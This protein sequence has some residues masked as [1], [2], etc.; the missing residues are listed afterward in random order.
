VSDHFLIGEL[1]PVGALD[2]SVE[3]QD[4]TKGFRLE[5]AKILEL[6]SSLVN[7]LSDLDG[8]P[9]QTVYVETRGRGNE[10]GVAQGTPSGSVSHVK[11]HLFLL[12]TCPGHITDSSVNQPSRATFIPA[13]VP[14]AIVF[15][16]QSGFRAHELR[17]NK[18][19]IS[20]LVLN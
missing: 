4:T 17:L 3:D 15:L 8:K 10:A 19:L 11:D 7:N 16:A 6:G 1:I 14:V 9:L 18:A 12:L 5:D 13:S 20:S 2:Y